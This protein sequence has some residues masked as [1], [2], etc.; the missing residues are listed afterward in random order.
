LRA[1]ALERRTGESSLLLINNQ[2]HARSF[3]FPQP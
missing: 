3:Q 2:T 1:G